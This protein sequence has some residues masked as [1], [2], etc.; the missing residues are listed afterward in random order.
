MLEWHH[1]ILIFYSLFFVCLVGFFVYSLFVYSSP[2]CDNVQRMAASPSWSTR[3]T[4][5][6]GARSTFLWV[7]R[8]LF[9]ATVKRRKL[10]CFGHV[11]G[12]YS[13]SKTTLQGTLEGGRRRG[14]QRKC[15]LDSV[16]EWTSLPLPELFTMASRKTNK[17]KN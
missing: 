4:T 12:N 3:P 1:V 11:T 15:W 13:L 16:K 9:L 5:G 10:T 7:L 6:W 8:N 2:F 17:Q 14:R